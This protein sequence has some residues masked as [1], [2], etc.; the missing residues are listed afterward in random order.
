MEAEYFHHK[1]NILLK[2]VIGCK[3]SSETQRSHDYLE[4]ERH[5]YHRIAALNGVI[6]PQRDGHLH[7]HIMIY[8]SVLSPEL[9]QKAAISPIK[10]QE[11]IGQMLDSITCTTLPL[12]IHKWYNDIISSIK[13]GEKCPQAADIGVP[14]AAPLQTTCQSPLLSVPAVFGWV[15]MPFSKALL[16][17]LLLSV[18]KYVVGPLN[19]TISPHL[20]AS[21]SSG[22]TT[23]RGSAGPPISTKLH[24]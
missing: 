10:V 19:V 11:Q 15:D 12:H 3:T 22:S 8:S 16:V 2:A 7:W 9:L 17:P 1:L 14:D 20:I 18:Y 23:R 24:V 13:L 4:Y 21:G 5:A 6:E